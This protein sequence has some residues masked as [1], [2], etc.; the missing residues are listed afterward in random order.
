MASLPLHLPPNG[1]SEKYQL[2]EIYQGI[3]A[4]EVDS[5]NS[6][7]TKLTICDLFNLSAERLRMC[8]I[9]DL[10]DC[11]ILRYESCYLSYSYYVFI[12]L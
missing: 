1:G 10:V 8:F 2:K 11:A 6:R 9:G 3:F 5:G 4:G 12:V 7:I